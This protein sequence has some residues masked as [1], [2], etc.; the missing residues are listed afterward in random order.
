MSKPVRLCG[1]TGMARSAYE[2][3]PS[4]NMGHSSTAAS[5]SPRTACL[6][7]QP[8]AK[9]YAGCGLYLWVCMACELRYTAHR[10][11]ARCSSQQHVMPAGYS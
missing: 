5:D 10:P 3:S 9:K 2:Q 6:A 4:H 7:Q 11:P 1:P 8:G